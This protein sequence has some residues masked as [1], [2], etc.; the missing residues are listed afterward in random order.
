MWTYTT[1][2]G[3]LD[4]AALTMMQNISGTITGKL[5]L[6]SGT[7][8]FT[9]M[10]DH[11]GVMTV[12]VTEKQKKG[13]S[14]RSPIILTL[15][16]FKDSSLMAIH[17]SGVAAGA[18]VYDALPQDPLPVENWTGAITSG[19]DAAVG[20]VTMKVSA[21]QRV[22]VALRFLDGTV[23]TH[24][25]RVM[26]SSQGPGPRGLAMMKILSGGKFAF[27][28]SGSFFVAGSVR[29]T[30]S[31]R[32]IRQEKP[33]ASF[34]PAGIS[35]FMS[36]NAYPFT[37][38]A[39]GQRALGFLNATEGV[40]KL[41]VTDPNNELGGDVDLPLTLDANNK[42]VFVVDAV[43]KPTLK[44]NVTTGQVTGTVILGGKKRNILGTLYNGANPTLQGYIT[45][46][47][48][49]VKFEVIP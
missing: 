19:G 32:Y 38:P 21:S 28:A 7:Y 2:A 11:A 15:A 6:R 39:A 47:G 8:P 33:G 29:F 13:A 41:R 43:R 9:G 14:P 3:V 1:E 17:P 42:F 25:G 26:G 48:E 37:K 18:Y 35:T 16:G 22:S 12:A 23:G 31:G 46:A 34:Y 5:R 24:S 20:P 4:V 27:Q 44:L 10:L 30:G 49:N 45:G 36:L 40:G